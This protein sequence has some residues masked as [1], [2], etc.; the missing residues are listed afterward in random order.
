MKVGFHVGQV[1]GAGVDLQQQWRDHLEQARAC[2]DA[3]FDLVSW[4]HHWLI[5]PFQ[6]FQPVPALARLAAE[7]LN[8]REK[9]AR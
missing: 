8:I 3:G 9:A 2:R 4:G 1:V 5:H 6:H 7:E